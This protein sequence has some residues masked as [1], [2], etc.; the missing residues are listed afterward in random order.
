[1]DFRSLFPPGISCCGGH[2]VLLEALL[3]KA[4]ELVVDAACVNDRTIVI[5]MH[6]TRLQCACPRCGGRSPRVHGRYVRQPADLPACGYRVRLLL[7]V[8]RFFCDDAP[9]PRR[10]FTERLLPFL[11]PY[12]RRT[13]RLA[14]QQLHVASVAGGEGGSRLLA[15]LAMPASSA[16]LLRMIRQAP[17]AT[18]S[19]PQVLGIDDWAKRKGHTYG[20]IL[21]DLE[22]RRVVDP[23]RASGGR[24]CHRPRLRNRRGDRPHAGPGMSAD[25]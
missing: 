11:A 18:E 13:H 7:T 15:L 25:G 23:L 6:S 1:M 21:V 8:R 5:E 17:E 9:C 3:P 4:C 24:G 14:G 12:A 19:T 16:T 20:T 10:T 2:R 22:E